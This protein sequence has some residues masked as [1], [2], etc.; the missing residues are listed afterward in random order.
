MAFRDLF[1]LVQFYLMN[2]IYA[3]LFIWALE[4]NEIKY[5]KPATGFVC[6]LY[7]TLSDQKSKPSLL[8]KLE[9]ILNS[10]KTVFQV[11][12]VLYLAFIKIIIPSYAIDS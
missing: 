4:M 11:L 7:L 6:Y 3:C 12:F 9:L 8:C 10:V 5:Q 1:L 2:N